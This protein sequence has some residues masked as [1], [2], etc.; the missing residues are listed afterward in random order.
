VAATVELAAGHEALGGLAAAYARCLRTRRPVY[1]YA[2]WRGGHGAHA[3]GG[4]IDRLLVPCSAGGPGVTHVMG[5]VLIEA[6]GVAASTPSAADA[7]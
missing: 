6:D 5:M 2:R 4:R 3:E 1:D 7:T